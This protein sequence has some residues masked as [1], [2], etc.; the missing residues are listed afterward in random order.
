MLQVLGVD[1]HQTMSSLEI[2]QLTGKQHK[3]VLENIRKVLE[4]AE[5]NSAEFSAQYKD[6]TGRTLPCFKLHKR[7]CDL[8]IAGYSVKYRLAIID[9]WAELEAREV[10]SLPSYAEALRELANA[11]D[12]NV[13][14]QA[15][16]EAQKPAVAFHECVKASINCQT[17]EEISKA[18]GTGR[19]RM[20]Q[21][22]RNAGLLKADNNPYQDYIDRGY[23]EVE[24]RTYKDKNH[25]DVTYPM[26]MVTGRGVDYIYRKFF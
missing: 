7:E 26:T 9:R 20:Y 25:K 19:N 4:E 14:Q 10:K 11:L 17:I 8:V 6:S 2:A 23:F 24:L 18:L 22:L 13:A 12:A 3:D 15:V 16:I 5:I 21:W 1:K